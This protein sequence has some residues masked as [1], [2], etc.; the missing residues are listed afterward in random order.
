MTTFKIVFTYDVFFSA[1][2]TMHC[3]V[4]CTGILYKKRAHFSQLLFEYFQN[5]RHSMC[6][7]I[8]HFILIST[9]HV[10]F[11]TCL[12]VFLFLERKQDSNVTS[13][14]TF[15]RHIQF[16]AYLPENHSYEE[17]LLKESY[18]QRNI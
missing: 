18:V 9:V 12:P 8:I 3:I 15:C 7:C 1:E 11:L 10:L 14:K 5:Y 13:V 6:F 2:T 4:T 16:L 17:W